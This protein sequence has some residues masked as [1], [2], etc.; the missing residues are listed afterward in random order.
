MDSERWAR[1][2]NGPESEREMER[3]ASSAINGER[4]GG[5]EIDEAAMDVSQQE[6]EWRRRRG[7]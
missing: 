1:T 7:G 2:K 5:G 6:S 3:D 4:G